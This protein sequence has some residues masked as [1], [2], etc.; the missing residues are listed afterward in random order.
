MI[1]I[2][3]YWLVLIKILSYLRDAIKTGKKALLPN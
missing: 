2:A 1:G 3:I